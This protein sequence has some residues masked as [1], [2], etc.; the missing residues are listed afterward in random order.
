MTIIQFP[1]T[2]TKATQYI[3]RDEAITRIKAAL[4]ARS[5][6]TWSV[7]GGKGTAWGWLTIDVQPKDRRWVDVAI[8]GMEYRFDLPLAMRYTV[9]ELTS[10]E[11]AAGKRGSMGPA[12][13]RLL[14]DLLGFTNPVHSQGQDV[15][16]SNDYYTEYV[17]RAEGRQPEVYGTQYWD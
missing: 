12:D 2:A 5:G 10:E 6:R 4:K 7:T 11:W 14:A 15:P 17:A 9:R 3:S 13:Q 1:A 16:A 8:P